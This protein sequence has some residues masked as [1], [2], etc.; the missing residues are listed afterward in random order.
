MANGPLVI[1]LKQ[2]PFPLLYMCSFS[3][4]LSSSPM[5]WLWV[6]CLYIW[7]WWGYLWSMCLKLWSGC[8]RVMGGSWL[9][10]GGWW[11]RFRKRAK[12]VVRGLPS[13]SLVGGRSLAIGF[14]AN[15]IGR[16]RCSHW[17]HN[18]ASSSSDTTVAS[19]ILSQLTHRTQ[20]IVQLLRSTH[21]G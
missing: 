21:L 8:L 15:S 9:G 3:L 11:V 2:S 19:C 16:R 6:R 18:R 5:G 20:K 7:A 4:N 14:R 17:Y 13:T 1:H 12:P 10:V